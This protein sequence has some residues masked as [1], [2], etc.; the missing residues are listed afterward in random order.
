MDEKALDQ[1]LRV[2]RRMAAV[3]KKS[4]EWRPISFTKPGKRALRGAL[5]IG[6]PCT[7]HDSPMRRLKQ[8]AAF[9]QCSRD[10]LRG[11]RPS[12]TGR[13]L[14]RIKSFGGSVVAAG[15]AIRA[16]GAQ[17]FTPAGT[18]SGSGSTRACLVNT[19]NVLP[20]YSILVQTGTPRRDVDVARVT[21][22]PTLLSCDGTQDE[23]TPIATATI[24]SADNFIRLSVSKRRF[25]S[26]E[27]TCG[28]YGNLRKHERP[29]H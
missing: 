15:S 16:K 8:S 14:A 24:A 5:G 20:A 13:Y 11:W 21:S 9:L 28:R 26:M 27:P 12:P 17:A 25:K 23:D 2:G 1:V 3:P 7:Q 10:C 19:Q 18:G 22:G 6:F 29:T 4:V